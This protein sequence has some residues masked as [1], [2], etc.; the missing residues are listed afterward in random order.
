LE[1]KAGS[2]NQY[3]KAGGENDFYVKK[4]GFLFNTR[5]F[6]ILWGSGL[7]MPTCASGDAQSAPTH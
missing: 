2:E 5:I 7:H 1:N 6:S 4:E 3:A